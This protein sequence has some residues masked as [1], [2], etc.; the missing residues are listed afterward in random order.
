MRERARAERSWGC[1]YGDELVREGS[2]VVAVL[3]LVV[4]VGLLRVVLSR[5]EEVVSSAPHPRP[6]S[7]V[8]EPNDADSR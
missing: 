6:H 4:G 7:A 2:L 3:E 1:A 5:G 8:A